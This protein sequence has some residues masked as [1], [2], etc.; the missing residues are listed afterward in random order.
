MLSAER[1]MTKKNTLISISIDDAM[2]T[3]VR[4]FYRE[5]GIYAYESLIPQCRNT[6]KLVYFVS[7][8]KGDEYGQF[9]TE[10]EATLHARHIAILDEEQRKSYET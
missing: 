5:N 3:P 4:E 7:G 9:D 8:T 1:F 2:S 10:A 6:A